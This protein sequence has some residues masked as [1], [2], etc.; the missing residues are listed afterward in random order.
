MAT[1]VD[2][3]KRGRHAKYPWVEWTDGRSYLAHR[4]YDFQ[5]SP[6]SFRMILY[7]RAVV[8]GKRVETSIDSDGD[9]WFQFSPKNKAT[10]AR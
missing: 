7:Q 5:C 2:S 6:V 4:H 3:F 8:E 10:K 1:V 9:V